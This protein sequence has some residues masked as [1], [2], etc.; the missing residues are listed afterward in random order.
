MKILAVDSVGKPIV[1]TLIN[2]DKNYKK[3]LDI[4][5]NASEF[6]LTMVD[7]ILTENNFSLKDMAK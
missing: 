5:Q 7:D 6:L 2:D 3:T 4:S 1:V